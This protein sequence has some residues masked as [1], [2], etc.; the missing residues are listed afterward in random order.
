MRA[1]TWQ[2]TCVTQIST[3][4][5]QFCDNQPFK[6]SGASL[7]AGITTPLPQG[8]LLQNG[9]HAMQWDHGVECSCR[10]QQRLLSCI[11][12]IFILYFSCLCSPP[13]PFI[14][15]LLNL[16]NRM[17]DGCPLGEAD[18]EME[19]EAVERAPPLNLNNRLGFYGCGRG[20]CLT[21]AMDNGEGGG[22]DG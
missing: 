6:A 7:K 14:P 13:S 19:P 5:K 10:Q 16:H 2:K 8:H 20:Q 18:T 22:S 12:I 17:V 3:T 9:Q 1:T 21:A 4:L 11:V 15:P